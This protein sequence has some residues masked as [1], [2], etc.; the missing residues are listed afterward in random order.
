MQLILEGLR[1]SLYLL[2][3]GEGEIWSIAWL[4]IRVSSTAT[5]LSVLLG[6]PCGAAIALS[7]FPGKRFLQSL[8]NSAMGLPP[9]VVGLWVSLLL[10]RSGP[11]G[12]L[13]LMYTPA[14]LVLAQ[15]LIAAP[16]VAALT[17]AGVMQVEQG[18]AEQ[19]LGL[20]ASRLQQVYLVLREAWLSLLAAAMAG[21][22][23]VVAEVGAAMA[24][25]G[26]IRG[27]T[28]TLSTAI[29][30]EINR[31]NFDTALAL[32][33]L[34]LTLSYSVALCLTALQRRRLG[35]A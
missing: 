26:N 24:V 6:I 13:S 19:I 33:F 8:A 34:L 10:W 14:A 1:Q 2:F 29:V 7:N 11:L 27:Q 22:G 15:V 23:A 5:L 20:G 9:V 28:R 35:N 17:M 18:I 3:T 16:R 32:S 25:G 12:N 21:F 30:L 31:G 4:T